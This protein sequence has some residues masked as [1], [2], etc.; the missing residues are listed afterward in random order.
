MSGRGQQFA[1]RWG[2]L[3]FVV[4]HD[5]SQAQARYKSQKEMTAAAGRDSE[6]I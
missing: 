4:Y 1:A 5:L 3:L 2:E 6:S